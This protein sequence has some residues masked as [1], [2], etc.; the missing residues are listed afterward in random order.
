MAGCLA[1]EGNEGSGRRETL[2]QCGT[3]LL[4]V[5]SARY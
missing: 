3:T 2:K 4:P 5:S 1:S